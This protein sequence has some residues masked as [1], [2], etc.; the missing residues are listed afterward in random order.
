MRSRASEILESTYCPA[1][2]PTPSTPA[3]MAN[4]VLFRRSHRREADIMMMG[5]VVVCYE[6]SPDNTYIISTEEQRVV[7]WLNE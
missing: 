3:P 7:R 1:M 5:A 4:L 2:Y 6:L